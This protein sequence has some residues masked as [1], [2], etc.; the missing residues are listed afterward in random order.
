[1]GADWQDRRLEKAERRGIAGYFQPQMDRMYA[2][3][4]R[5]G[6]LGIR[7]LFLF[8]PLSS[9]YILSICGSFSSKWGESATK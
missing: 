4:E 9:A 8:P 7:I 2:D 3:G 1:M 6:D 5:C